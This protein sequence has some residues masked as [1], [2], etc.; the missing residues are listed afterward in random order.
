MNPKPITM[1]GIDLKHNLSHLRY[2][3]IKVIGISIYV[4]V[5]NKVIKKPIASYYAKSVVRLNDLKPTW[6]CMYTTEYETINQS[7]NHIQ[8]ITSISYF[9]RYDLSRKQC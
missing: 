7:I 9:L 3:W 5:N 1:C 8:T 4:K 2:Y 6:E